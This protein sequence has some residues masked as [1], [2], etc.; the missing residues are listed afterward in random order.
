MTTLKIYEKTRFRNF[1]FICQFS[2]AVKNLI[3]EKIFARGKA[4]EFPLFESIIQTGLSME[5]SGGC[6]LA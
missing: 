2:K 4:Q 5:R 6:R 3:Y 1:E